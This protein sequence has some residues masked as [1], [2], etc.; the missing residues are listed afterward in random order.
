MSVTREIFDAPTIDG[1]ADQLAEHMPQGKAWEAKRVEGSQ[2]RGV[3]AAMAVPNNRNQ[4]LIETLM[5]EIDVNQTTLLIDEWEE[6]VGLPDACLGAGGTLEQRRSRVIER[7]RRTPI[8][9]LAEMQGLIDAFFPDRGIRL[10]AGRDFFTFEYTFEASFLGDVD[11][12][13]ILVAQVPS[14][15]PQFEYDFEID[16]VAGLNLD[17]LRCVLERVIPSNVYLFI[18]EV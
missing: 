18:D 14:Q 5:R 11:E 17:Q 10:I 8:V 9:T 3:V 7:L 16:L 15:D 1:S 13:F 2:M 4:Q 12:R 6:S